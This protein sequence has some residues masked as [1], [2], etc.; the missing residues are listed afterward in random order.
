MNRGSRCATLFALLVAGTSAH[1]EISPLTLDDALKLAAANSPQLHAQ[2][3][4]AEAAQARAIAAGRLPDPELIAGVENIPITS[5]DAWSVSRDFMTM[6][7][8]GVMQSVPN[9]RKRAG[10]RQVAQ[11]GIEMVHA[12]T[13]ATELEVSRNT[14]EAWIDTYAAEQ[15]EA[16]L[17]GL[18]TELQ[19]QSEAARAAIRAVRSPVSEALSVQAALLD[20][21]DQLIEAQ[22][23][24]RSSRA[25]LARWIGPDEATRTLSAPPSFGEL[26]RTRTAVLSSLHQ[27]A[28][29]IAYQAQI[30]LVESE[31]DRERA[32]GRADWSAELSYAKRGDAFSDMVTLQFRVGLPF[33]T[34]NRQQP[35][36]NAKRADLAE[37]QAQRE[38]E[39]RMH[40]EEVTTTFAQWEG[41][42]D[43]IALFERERL[44]LAR[45][46][47]QSS[48]ASFRAGN[49]SL[50][51]ALESVVSEVELQRSHA[52][53][54]RDFGRAWAYLRYLSAQETAP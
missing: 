54:L 24:V 47:A 33:F 37:L 25:M 8:L 44:P 18:R 53:L 14:S 10:D 51:N 32:N 48:L 35:L 17:R 52:L 36:I 12:Q 16:N 29:L 23:D 41:A 42:R 2:A 1:A 5:A 46:R 26:P 40:V 39:L 7:K 6:R 4:A 20:L 27:H 3:A 34:R 9:A 15:L 11:A 30:H 21:E 19:L 22:R 31:V 45:A 43:R 38:L 13:R 49:G 28:F 50:T